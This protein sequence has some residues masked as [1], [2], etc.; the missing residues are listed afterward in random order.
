MAVEVRDPDQ[1]RDDLR[2]S[3]KSVAHD[4]NNLLYRLALLSDAMIE[5]ASAPAAAQDTREMLLDT[6]RRL[7][8]AIDRLRQMSAGV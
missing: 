3:I 8:G 4:L 7:E 2:R 5:T 6:R 1:S